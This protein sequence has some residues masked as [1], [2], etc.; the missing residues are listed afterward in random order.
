M[1]SGGGLSPLQKM[2]SRQRAASCRCPFNNG[3]RFRSLLWNNSFSPNPSG[4]VVSRC[5]RQGVRSRGGEGI[6]H[7]ASPGIDPA[8]NSTASGIFRPGPSGSPA[9]PGRP[10]C[11]FL[12][13]LLPAWVGRERIDLVVI[14]PQPARFR[15]AGN[16]HRNSSISAWVKVCH[17]GVLGGSDA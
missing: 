17:N 7:S 3:I 6:D 12:W 9:T 13:I 4:C 1:F 8:R 15:L 2:I 10:R 5:F 16:P 11:C 14:P